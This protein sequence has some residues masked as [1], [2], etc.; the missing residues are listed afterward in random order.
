MLSNQTDFFFPL[1]HWGCLLC[2]FYYVAE[3]DIMQKNIIKIKMLKTEL[4]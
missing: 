4:I 2:H 1:G 3:F